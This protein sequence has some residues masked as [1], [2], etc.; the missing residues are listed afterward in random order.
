MR[1][2]AYFRTFVNN[3]LNFQNLYTHKGIVLIGW[4]GGTPIIYLKAFRKC[5]VIYFHMIGNIV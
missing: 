3:A 4:A 1:R 2:R 5:C